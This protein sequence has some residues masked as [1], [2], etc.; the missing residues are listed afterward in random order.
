MDPCTFVVIGKRRYRKA[1]ITSNNA[2]TATRTVMLGDLMKEQSCAVTLDIRE[3][4]TESAY[5]HHE[6]ELPVADMSYDESKGLYSIQLRIDS[7]FYGAIIGKRGEKKE[8]IQAATDTVIMVPKPNSKEQVVVVT[9]KAPSSL[10]MAKEKIMQTVKEAEQRQSYT[11]FLSL[12]L[13]SSNIQSKVEAVKGDIISQF[14][15]IQ[16]LHESMFVPASQFHLTLLMLRLDSD[17]SISKASQVL[18]E[19]S[20]SLYDILGTRTALIRLKGIKC[21]GSAQRAD[22]LYVNVENDEVKEKL[23]RISVELSKRFVESGLLS[24]ADLQRQRLLGSDG[25]I[26]PVQLHATVVNTRY[27]KQ[28][29]SQPLDASQIIKQFNSFDLGSERI[30]SLHLSERFRFDS[31]GYY[32]CVKAVPF[33]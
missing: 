1:P 4:E 18:T 13:T 19:V 2:A 3:T 24:S 15:W 29:Q 5:T 28:P 6:D 30:P 22:V 14:S 33:P 23:E 16:G 20:S 8:K 7:D 9:G 17:E 32:H 11:H 10:R 25:A 27:S 26:Q 12:P 31:N 21:F